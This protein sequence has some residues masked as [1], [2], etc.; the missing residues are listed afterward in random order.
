MNIGL[1]SAFGLGRKSVPPGATLHSKYLEGKLKADAQRNVFVE[2]GINKCLD[3]LE[4]MRATTEDLMEFNRQRA[5]AGLYDK[6]S[7]ANKREVLLSN[8]DSHL[9]RFRKEWGSD[10][11]PLIKTLEID[12]KRVKSPQSEADEVKALAALLEHTAKIYAHL[13]DFLTS[14]QI[15]TR[16]LNLESAKAS[17]LRADLEDWLPR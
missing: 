6:S 7:F 17:R 15:I 3:V 9:S 2:T 16:E 13:K 14:D 1:L 12:V 5:R 8:L 4:K 10:D 11:F